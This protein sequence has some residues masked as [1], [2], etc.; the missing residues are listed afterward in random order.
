MDLPFGSNVH[1]LRYNGY[2]VRIEE[3]LSRKFVFS[4]LNSILEANLVKGE[5]L[6]LIYFLLLV[7]A[8]LSP[9]LNGAR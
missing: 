2:R 1:T 4:I 7:T 6:F 5:V 9:A 8:I 3:R